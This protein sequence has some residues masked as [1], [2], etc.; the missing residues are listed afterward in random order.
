[1][2]SKDRKLS[3]SKQTIKNL[4]TRLPLE[5]A[6]GGVSLRG[7]CDPVYTYHWDTCWNCA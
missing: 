7:S 6:Q 2:K 5:Q 3:L 1:M 4:E